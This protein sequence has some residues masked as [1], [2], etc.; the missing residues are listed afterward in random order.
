MERTHKLGMIGSI[1]GLILFAFI[2]LFFFIISLLP[3]M[4]GWAIYLWEI[5]KREKD[6]RPR[7]RFWGIF[8]AFGDV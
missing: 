1:L 3:Y 6:R 4:R 5:I 7:P 2:M 8:N